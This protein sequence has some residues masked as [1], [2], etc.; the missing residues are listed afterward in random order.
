MKENVAEISLSEIN[1]I[2]INPR[3]GHIGFASFVINGQFYVGRV[4]IHSTPSGEIRLLYSRET[5]SNGTVSTAFH[6]ITKYAG[7]EITRQVAAKWNALISRSIL[8]G[9]SHET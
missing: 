4:G 6:P 2:P 9:Y 3:N 1:I 8:R 5:L 7:L